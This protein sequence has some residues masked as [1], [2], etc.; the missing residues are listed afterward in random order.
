MPSAFT[1]KLSRASLDVRRGRAEKLYPKFR[2]SNS[3]G[4]HLF[5]KTK[6]ACCCIASVRLLY[7]A[8]LYV[9]FS[10]KHESFSALGTN[11]GAAYRWLVRPLAAWKK[12]NFPSQMHIDE[13]DLVENSLG[14]NRFRLYDSS[15][16]IDK[17][18]T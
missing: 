8:P 9:D 13:Y 12:L 11:C 4:A 3:C 5:P 10:E 2:I 6:F 15:N 16:R 7:S 1:R 17:S 14:Y 18:N